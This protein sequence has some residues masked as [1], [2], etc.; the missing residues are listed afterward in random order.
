MPPV[1]VNFNALLTRLSIIYLIRLGSDTIVLG[2]LLSKIIL[3]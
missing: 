1:L 2:T 3:K